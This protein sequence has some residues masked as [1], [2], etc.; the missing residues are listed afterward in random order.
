MYLQLEISIVWLSL[1]IWIL[2]SLRLHSHPYIKWQRL[3]RTYQQLPFLSDL[4]NANLCPSVL[5]ELK[6]RYDI[7]V[8][9]KVVVIKQNGAVITNKGRKQIRERGLACFQNWVE[10]AD[11][12][13]NFSG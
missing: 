6:K 9:P 13:Q 8:I 11:V 7:T 4:L 1:G 2:D 10:A 3:H 12:F 5:S